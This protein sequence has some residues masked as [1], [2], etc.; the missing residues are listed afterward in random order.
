MSA[1]VLELRQRSSYGW[2]SPTKLGGILL[3]ILLWLGGVICAFPL[4]WTFVSSFR[5]DVSFL[6]SPFLFSPRD[7][8]VHNYQLAFNGNAASSGGSLW[9]GFKNTAVQVSIILVTTMF[10]CPLAGYGFAK[11]RFPG[12][13]VLFGMMMLTLFFVPITQYIPLLIE[14]N[15]LQWVDTYQAL[16]MPLVISSLGIFWMTGVTRGVPDELLQAGRV[17]GC[18]SFVV[19]FRIVMPVI[20]P[21]LVSLA[22]VS[23]LGA[24]NDFFWPLLILPSPDMQTIQVVL[25]LFTTA[26]FNSETGSA[27]NWGQ[28]LAASSVVFIPTVAVFLAMQRYF[29]RGMLEGSIKQ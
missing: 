8:M 20:R 23:F 14:M 4:V 19:W 28:V 13:N 6:T 3:V 22:V 11:F 15:S 5:P 9:V 10:F 17:D 1:K 27:S 18:N 2:P 29:I 21:A 24:Y 12:R 7:L 26:L 25:Q 16:V